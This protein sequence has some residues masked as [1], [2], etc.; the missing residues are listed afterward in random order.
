MPE[1]KTFVA[2]DLTD[3]DFSRLH[4]LISAK[5]TFLLLYSPMCIHCQMFKPTWGKVVEKSMQDAQIRKHVQ[6]LQIQGDD[7]Y[8]L[9]QKNPELFKYVTTTRTSADVYFPK[10]MVFVKDGDKVKKTVYEKDRDESLLMK[11][12]RSK[13][14]KA[15]RAPRQKLTKPIAKP[16]KHKKIIVKGARREAYNDAQFMDIVRKNIGSRSEISLP[17]LIDEMMKKYLI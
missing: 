13:I 9:K 1:K 15:T 5:T 3:K 16:V 14:P 6:F 12:I 7:L 8:V 11:Y 17:E 4:K 2:K 10:L